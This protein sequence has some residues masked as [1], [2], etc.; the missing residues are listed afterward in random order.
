MTPRRAYEAILRRGKDVPHF[1]AWHGRG[2][3]ARQNR[4][5]LQTLRGKHAGERCFVMGNGPSLARMDLTRLGREVTIGTNR[6]YLLFDQWQFMPTYYVCINELV[7]E[8]FTSD[9]EQLPMP[10]FLNWN[11]RSLF[12]HANNTMFLRV[13]LGIQDHFC[14]DLAKTIASGGT[15][16]FACLQLAY[17]LGFDEVILIGLDHS[18]VEKGIPNTTEVRTAETDQSHCHPNYF[19]KGVK[20]QLPDLFR[21]E[22]A[23]A[24]AR[25][26]FE[27][28]GKRIVDATERGHCHVFEKAEFASFFGDRQDSLPP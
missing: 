9:I 6:V 7:L 28:A 5:T 19:P 25:N 27:R 24:L 12:R 2:N 11:R 21:S 8:Q 4:A 17:Y 22:R 20:W 26:A 1:A 13:G 14:R 16:T 10:K 3:L 23:Y 18:F 15:V